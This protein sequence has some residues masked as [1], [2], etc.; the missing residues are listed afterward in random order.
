MSLATNLTSLATRIA[1][2]CKA[3]RTLIN[4]NAAGLTALATTNKTNLVAAVNELQGLISTLGSPIQINDLTT[5]LVSTWSS[6]KINSAITTAVA[7]V[8]GGS[9]AALDTLNELA[10]A[11]G[12]DANFATTTATALG[13]RVRV[14]AAQSFTSGEKTQALQNIGAADATAVGDTTTDFVAAFTAGLV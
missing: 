10:T 1:T 13:K 4:G 11:L 8:V 12:N 14:D 9:A 3:I 2:E 7:G 5:G 6:T